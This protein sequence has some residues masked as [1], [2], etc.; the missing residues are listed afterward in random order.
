MK[1]AAAAVVAEDDAPKKRKKA[2]KPTIQFKQGA[3]A[4][5][6]VERML[7]SKNLKS[8]VNQE[9]LEEFF[10]YGPQDKSYCLHPSIAEYAIMFPKCS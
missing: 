1:K 10:K 2:K 7:E 8:R 5:E 4:Q 3:T 6:S 9:M